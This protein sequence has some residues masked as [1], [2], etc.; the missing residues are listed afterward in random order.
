MYSNGP[1]LLELLGCRHSCG[2]VARAELLEAARLPH[3]E[4]VSNPLHTCRAASRLT[5]ER[6]WSRRVI[7]V[8]KRS[9][10]QLAAATASRV[11]IPDAIDATPTRHST[12]RRRRF[13]KMLLERHLATHAQI[14]LSW[15]Y[16]ANQRHANP[17]PIGPRVDRRPFYN[18]SSREYGGHVPGE[19][20][21]LKTF[22]EDVERRTP[23]ITRHM[24]MVDGLVLS[25]DHSHKV[26]KLVHVAGTR[27][28]E[29]LYTLM[30][31]YGQVVGFW[32]VL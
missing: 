29:G 11:C 2:A 25:G 18:F 16:Y 22:V 17:A 4:A 21:L 1:M 19:P 23:F 24:Q 8:W 31:G 3:H 7:S 6:I 5:R 32:C 13:R 28:F 15:T 30:N 10:L 20:Y 14:S 9:E 26:A 12:R 27:A